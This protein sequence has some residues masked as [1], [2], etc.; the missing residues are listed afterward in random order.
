MSVDYEDFLMDSGFLSALSSY[1]I[2][3]Y[4]A[5]IVS[6]DFSTERVLSVITGK[7]TG[8]SMS[9]SSTS[10]TR[11]TGTLTLVF[12]SDTYNITDVNNLL[13]INK[14]IAITIKM[15]N[16]F[17]NTSEYGKYGSF[18]SFKFGTF[19]ISNI[20]SSI[21]TSGASITLT[22][23]D[24]MGMLNGTCGGTIPSAASFHESLVIDADGNST[25]E[26][27]LISEIIRELVHHF[28]GENYSKIIVDD[29]PDTGRSVVTWG[30]ST[31]ARFT[32]D[33][34][35]FIVT[36]SPTTAEISQYPIIILY[37]E[38]VGYLATDLTYPGDLIATIGNTVTSVL[39]S[40]VSTLGNYEYFYDVD[41]YFHFQAIKNFNTTGTAPTVVD[42]IDSSSVF[43]TSDGDEADITFQNQYLKIYSEDE[44]L[45]EYSDASLVSSVSFNPNYSNIKNDF[46]VWG[47]RTTDDDTEMA[48]RYHLAIDSR[49]K[50]EEGISL[51]NKT[52]WCVRNKTTREV[53]RYVATDMQNVD[54]REVVPDVGSTGTTTYPNVNYRG[55]YSDDS[56]YYYYP[57]V[58]AGGVGTGDTVLYSGLY[59][60]RKAT[61]TNSTIEGISPLNSSYWTLLDE[62][63]DEVILH[64]P[65]LNW[66]N[67]T[68][69]GSTTTYPD[70][71]NWREELYR[72]A[73][74]AYGTSTEGSYYDEELL[75]EWRNIFNP[76]LEDIDPGVTVAESTSGG[77]S[78]P[79]WS[80]FKDDWQDYFGQP[81]VTNGVESNPIPWQGYIIDIISA[82]Q[83]IG[84]WLDLIDTSSSLG[85]YSVEQIGRRTVAEDNSLIN[86]VLTRDVPD[87]LFI[88]STQDAD[89]VTAQTEEAI[90]IGQKY[91]VVNSNY[92]FYLTTRDSYGCCYDDVR[93]LF[94]NY[95]I[96]NSSI[97][98]TSI[99][100]LYLDVN[101]VIRLNFPDL[102]VV[103]NYVISSLSFDF[104]TMSS[105]SLSLTEAVVV[106]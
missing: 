77:Y 4:S 75:A 74:I 10:A 13:S 67:A 96:Y 11:R 101:K 97:S 37:G 16:P 66:L 81:I 88:D 19:I 94:Y 76:C 47:T 17:A 49:P 1:K 71:F 100:L 28:G 104:S 54:G 3:T 62:S 87:I 102:G 41:G 2:K 72:K 21:S 8:G 80:T 85:G 58:S 50:Y 56:E 29:V 52:V 90:S 22:F 20:T 23:I 59:Y 27:P 98:L 6:L 32:A 18:L 31:P 86:E 92:N 51:C 7:V 79:Y 44:Y 57:N 9:I 25:T 99:P 95:L 34:T 61:A 70:L 39:D 103:G 105:M 36:S 69:N 24:K 84:Y 83:N 53:L 33:Y 30:G 26:Y 15:E 42:Q 35:H 93:S 82:P 89:T 73:L 63:E 14:K 64:S 38:D 48:V 91:C 78:N 65:A 68:T 43:N 40:I 5:S 60:I 12:D 55:L 46:V 45:N 106:V